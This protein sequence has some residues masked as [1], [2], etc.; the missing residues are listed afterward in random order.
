MGAVGG[1]EPAVEVGGAEPAV[2]A[3]GGA[4]P[5]VE[6]GGAEPAIE[7]GGAEPVVEVGGAEPAVVE[8][9]VGVYFLFLQSFP[10]WQKLLQ[11]IPCFLQLH[12]LV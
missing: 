8:V 1:A 9:E 2:V 7:V 10:L 4:E 6:V 5:P 11:S 3:V 12:L